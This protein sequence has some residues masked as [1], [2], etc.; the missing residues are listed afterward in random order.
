MKA[1]TLL[2]LFARLKACPTQDTSFSAKLLA[3]AWERFN[4]TGWDRGTEP[5]PSVIAG[6]LLHDPSVAKLL[7]PAERGQLLA[8]CDTALTRYH[9][10]TNP[11]NHLGKLIA[12]TL[13]ENP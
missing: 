7:T 10:K 8:L 9:E 13:K 3:E 2:P 6:L 5:G 12:A 4:Y 11:P 1:H